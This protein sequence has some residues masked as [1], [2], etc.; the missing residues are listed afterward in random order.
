[1]LDLSLSA[2]G[3]RWYL[4]S[5]EMETGP[6]RVDQ[7]RSL[8]NALIN[9]DLH[10]VGGNEC[11][12]SSVKGSLKWHKLRVERGYG[13]LSSSCEVIQ[14]TLRMERIICSRTPPK[15]QIHGWN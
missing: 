6:Q 13:F 14:I 10:G 8:F 1:M 3:T 5:P 2:K 7:I 9:G 4:N 12:E 11:L 15:Q